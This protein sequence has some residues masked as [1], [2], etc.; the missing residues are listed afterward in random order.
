MKSL[1]VI[2]RVSAGYCGTLICF[3]EC[4]WNYTLGLFVRCTLVAIIYSVGGW[5][6][7]LICCTFNC[8]LIPVHS[9]GPTA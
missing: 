9:F 7:I 5:I 2:G 6:H 1:L 8:D 3:W 4:T